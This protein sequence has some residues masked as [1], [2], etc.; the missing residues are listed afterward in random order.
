MQKRTHMTGQ[1]RTL[2][3]MTWHNNTTQHNTTWHNVKN[4]KRWPNMR[5]HTCVPTYLHTYIPTYL[6]T[7]QYL[8]TYIP[9][10]VRLFR[11]MIIIICCT[12]HGRNSLCGVRSKDRCC[13]R[14]AELRTGTSQF[15]MEKSTSFYGLWSFSIAM[16]VYQ[17]VKQLELIGT[18]TAV[19]AASE[20][21]ATFLSV[22]GLAMSPLSL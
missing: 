5:S 11:Y 10:Y 8:H 12:T 22:I 17:H 4:H 16:S 2:H 1:D 18:R 9:T 21:I 15:L 6:H 14:C 3:D 7:W 13:P 20:I 19:T